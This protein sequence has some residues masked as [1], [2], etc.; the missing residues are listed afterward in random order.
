MKKIILPILLVVSTQVFS[1]SFRL[2]IGGGFAN[3]LG[4]LQQKKYSFDQVKGAYSFGGAYDITDQI[5]LRADFSKGSV[6][7]DDKKGNTK[8]QKRNLNFQSAITEV[9]LLVE[10]NW[11]NDYTGKFIPYAFTGLGA[12][13][14]NPYTFDNVGRKVFLHDLSTEGQGLTKYPN[15]KP[16]KLTQLNIPFGGGFKYNI[17]STIFI[18]GEIGIRKLF[19]DY[20]DD[21]SSSFADRSELLKAKGRVA[22]DLAFRGDE[23]PPYTSAYPKGGSQRGNADGKDWY[24]FGQF[25]VS[26]KLSW[27]DGYGS[28][29]ASTGRKGFLRRLGC[30]GGF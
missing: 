22:V 12:Y 18:A 17:S 11:L 5:V 6:G 15:S 26:F 19:T 20:L 14:F 29:G 25:R 30:P 2:H 9:A 10:Y 8:L 23:L 28:R 1:Q 4:D 3:Y 27:R 7:G 16:Y 13:K 21:V 24:Y